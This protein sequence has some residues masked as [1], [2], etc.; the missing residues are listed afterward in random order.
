M[1][2]DKFTKY[3]LYFL[4]GILAYYLLFN[5][6]LVEGFGAD[7]YAVTITSAAGGTPTPITCEKVTK[8]ATNEPKILTETA[9]ETSKKLKILRK[10]IG[11]I[12]DI[13]YQDIGTSETPYTTIILKTEAPIPC[14]SGDDANCPL[15]SCGRSAT[16]VAVEATCTTTVNNVLTDATCTASTA[17]TGDGEVDCS[18]FTDQSSCESLGGSGKCTFAA[19]GSAAVECSPFTDQV[20]CE[21]LG[22]SGKCTFAAGSAATICL[23]FGIDQGT[24]EGL[25]DIGKCVYYE[26]I[27]EGVYILHFPKSLETTYNADNDED[28]INIYYY[29]T[30]DI[31][32]YVTESNSF[33]NLTDSE[34]ITV[35]PDPTVTD[36]NE[37]SQSP[38]QNGGVCSDSSTDNTVEAGTYECACTGSYT[39]ENCETAP[40]VN[41]SWTC[42]DGQAKSGTTSESDTKNCARCNPGFY[43]TTD[44]KP[45]CYKVGN[46]INFDE[47]KCDTGFSLNASATCQNFGSDCTKSNQCCEDNFSVEIG[48][49]ICIII[50]IAI[51]V[52][53]IYLFSS[54]SRHKQAH[55][56]LSDRDTYRYKRPK[57]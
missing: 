12:D 46:C 44:S 45:K 26:G 13:F 37:C 19:A 51:I 6:G 50:C 15:S 2:M 56:I 54:R 17:N 47:T 55:N 38:C 11:T 29:K 5:N 16:N 18:P 39:G 35:A 48:I 53:T 40:H 32:K 23:R 14:A 8:T 33:I 28:N 9:D 49:T 42:P 41:A 57:V 34:T 20:S 1:D 7:N 21:G 4:V 36:N 52:G 25:G 30:I 24:C 22:D 3:A 10:L 31:K 43:K 27:P